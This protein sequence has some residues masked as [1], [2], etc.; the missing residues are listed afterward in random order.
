MGDYQLWK[1]PSDGGNPVP[2]TEPGV[3]LWTAWS[4]DSEYIYFVRGPNIWVVSADGENE[5]PITDLESKSGSIQFQLSTDGRYIYFSW[6]EGSGDIWVMDV[7]SGK[8]Y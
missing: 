6:Q 1:I 7:V 2:V 8:T 5:H 4:L 3:S